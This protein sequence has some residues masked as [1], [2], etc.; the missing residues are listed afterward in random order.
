MSQEVLASELRA[1]I[2]AAV[3]HPDAAR[4]TVLFKLTGT[5]ASAS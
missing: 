2:G 1:L 5:A 3:H 4:M